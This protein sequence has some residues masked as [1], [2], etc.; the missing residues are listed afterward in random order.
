MSKREQ[1]GTPPPSLWDRKPIGYDIKPEGR[2]WTAYLV[3]EGDDE[4]GMWPLA[5]GTSEAR[6]RRAAAREVVRQ[7]H[8]YEREHNLPTTRVIL[9]PS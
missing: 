7:L 6:V 5:H 4:C 3:R 8:I 1:P 2:G 9:V